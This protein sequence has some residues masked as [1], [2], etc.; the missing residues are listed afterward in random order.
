LPHLS[1]DPDA[2]YSLEE[3]L[4]CAG[5]QL[6]EEINPRTVRLYATQ[7]LID[8]PDKE[9]RR[10]VYG[11]R[12]LLQLLL[13]RALAQRGLSLAAIAPLV[14]GSDAELSQQLL[15]L[16]DAPVMA[17]PAPEASNEAL[18]YL[19]ELGGALPPGVVAAA[20][21]PPLAMT[22]RPEGS[23]SLLRMLMP[24]SSRGGSG[25][26]LPS[27]RGSSIG[28]STDERNPRP[29][30]S[31]ISRANR[32][33]RFSLA[34]GIELHLCEAAP[35]PPPGRRREVWL[36]RLLDRLQQQLGEHP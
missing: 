35:I 8:R 26:P 6:G 29:S 17:S 15:Q 2:R 32:W 20:V 30:S 31:R 3:L 14:A 11:K 21:L 25:T 24:P 33:Q 36:Q 22:E 27:R 4:A 23:D 1:A 9:G 16:E 18:D 19:R 7:G 13:I 34:P 28:S 5:E 10:A 12:Q